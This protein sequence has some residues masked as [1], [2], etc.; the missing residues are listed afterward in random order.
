MS[1]IVEGVFVQ[2][3]I[4]K[5]VVNKYVPLENVKYNGSTL[6]QHIQKL[7]ENQSILNAKIEEIYKRVSLLNAQLV[8]NQEAT[9]KAI[10]VIA[11]QLESEKF[12]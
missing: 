6:K 2:L 4:D 10:E 8:Q 1:K 9:K 5:K 12:L 3:I 7:E 11:N